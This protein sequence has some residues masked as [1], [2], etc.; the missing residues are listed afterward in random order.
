MK[1]QIFLIALF[2]ILFLPLVSAVVRII[3]TDSGFST[4]S[5]SSLDGTGI[6]TNNYA[7]Y[8]QNFTKSSSIT[9]TTG[10]IYYANGT[11][12]ANG[13]FSGDFINFGEVNLSA[14]SNFCLMYDSNE[15]TYTTAFKINANVSLTDGTAW[16]RCEEGGG[17]QDDTRIG[18]VINVGMSNV[19]LL[20]GVVNGITVNLTSPS[21]N[22]QISKDT[23]QLFNATT[24][25]D[26]FSL[27]N[28][29]LYL[30]F[31]N[32]TTWKTQTNTSFAGN[33][34]YNTLNLS[35]SGDF[36]WNVLG[37]QGNGAGIN[38]SFAT[39]NFTLSVRPF[40]VTQQVYN[41][42]VL[43]QSTQ[44][45][46]MV[47]IL[48]V[49]YSL[50]TI[51][52]NYNSTNY[53]GTFSLVNA[54]A[55]NISISII[56]PEIVA[57]INKSFYW[58]I[59][60]TDS[61]TFQSSTL[62]QQVNDLSIDGCSV[63]TIRIMNVSLVNE[64]TQV[65]LNKTADFTSIKINVE[66]YTN[67][68]L[69]SYAF[70]F[71]KWYNQT[72]PAEVCISDSIANS[73][74]FMNSIIEYDAS[75]YAHEFYHIQNYSL[76][77]SGGDWQNITLY[78]LND[79]QSQ[80]FKI[81]Y[82]DASFLAVPNALI[83]IQRKYIDENAFKTVEIPKTDTRGETVAHLQIADTIYTM[84]VIKNG[85]LLSTFSDIRAICD[86]QIVGDCTI[87]LNTFASSMDTGDFTQLNDFT[88]TISYA[89]STRTVSSVFTIPSG[90]TSIVLLNVTINS[91]TGLQQIC[92]NSLSTSSGTL[93]CAIP[94]IY[95]NQ[96]IIAT[97]YK[98][99]IFQGRAFIKLDQH[100]TTI[101]GVSLIFISIF[102]MMTLIGIGVSSDPKIFGIFLIMGAI[103]AI[104]LN[105]V[106][107][108]GIF[109]AS[110]TVLWLIIAIVL[111]LIKSSKR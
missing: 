79:T 78:D 80:N 38:S 25:N 55:Y 42:P 5:L 9:A 56:T 96:T 13:V 44:T 60:L 92:G 24:T 50:S 1:K 12:I 27:T 10:Y 19:S 4:G 62:T 95:G 90:A 82:K 68:S 97:V 22:S 88:F 111:V 14:N 89:N 103:L 70:N 23:S 45:F 87:N 41:S 8:I 47:L 64:E 102:M 26:T 85:I 28:A 46:K 101:F 16:S 74:Y 17:A 98:D 15:S 37:V 48:D 49:G 18:G 32:G 51:L 100:P 54:T 76:N 67:V 81:I 73:T 71:S 2:L 40:I 29:T 7:L 3:T 75:G 11:Q 20:G 84:L 53:T 57:D 35:I 36:Y 106:S 30:W 94:A 39:N 34:S 83:Q 91:Q 63:N 69:L 105:L 77:S 58:I 61:T 52:F 104:L 21:N 93:S 6:A 109:G 107:A 59:N 108:N 86:N 65:T 43:E 110:A 99:S 33:F 31:Q 66:L 72:L